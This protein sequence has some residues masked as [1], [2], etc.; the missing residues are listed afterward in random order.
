MHAFQLGLRAQSLAI[1]SFAATAS[2]EFDRVQTIVLI[3]ACVIAE[4]TASIA[5]SEVAVIR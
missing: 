2:H 3:L 4:D 5:S 1:L